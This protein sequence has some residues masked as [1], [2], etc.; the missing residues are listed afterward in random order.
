MQA[1]SGININNW[2]ARESIAGN[3]VSDEESCSWKLIMK[4]AALL[5]LS[6]SMAGPVSAALVVDASAGFATL[7][8]N[9]NPSRPL[10]TNT[11]TNESIDWSDG[12]LLYN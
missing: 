5:T 4:T 7:S 12:T 6:L 11:D 9:L 10:S 1:S 3:S 2:I 8:S